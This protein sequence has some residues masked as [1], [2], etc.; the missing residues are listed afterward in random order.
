MLLHML[1]VKLSS[2]SG[3]YST[4]KTNSYKKHAC[5]VSC[6]VIFGYY[7]PLACCLC[8]FRSK[9]FIRRNVALTMW[10]RGQPGLTKWPLVHCLGDK[11]AGTML[12]T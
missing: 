9:S 5:A 12:T 6:G 2:R 10:F 1:A 3:P 8:S 7:T 11:V 4:S